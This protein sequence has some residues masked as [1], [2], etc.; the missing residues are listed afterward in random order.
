MNKR[1]RL[2][3]LNLSRTSL[4]SLTVPDLDQVQGG[5]P[6]VGSCRTGCSPVCQETSE[7]TTTTIVSGRHC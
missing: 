2:P 5:R 3:R 1:T 7:T 6:D 4:R